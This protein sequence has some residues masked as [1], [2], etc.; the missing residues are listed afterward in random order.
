MKDTVFG[1]EVE[2]PLWIHQYCRPADPRRRG[3]VRGGESVYDARVGVQQ[4]HQDNVPRDYTNKNGKQVRIN[5]N[6]P[7]FLPPGATAVTARGN[8]WPQRVVML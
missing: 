4:F 7:F 8:R 1:N 5:Q 3:Y 6:N 2:L